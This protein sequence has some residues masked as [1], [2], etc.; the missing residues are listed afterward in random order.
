[1]EIR[2]WLRLGEHF[3]ASV[4]TADPHKQVILRSN[5]PDDI[6]LPLTPILPPNENVHLRFNC[7]RI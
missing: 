4:G 6:T 2:L 7:P 5:V 1:M 3:V